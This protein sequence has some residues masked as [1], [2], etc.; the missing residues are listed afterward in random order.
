MW[1]KNTEG[2]KDAM[3]SFA[4]AAFIVAFALVICKP[5]FESFPSFVT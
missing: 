3:L 1:I 4:T 2:K 5:E